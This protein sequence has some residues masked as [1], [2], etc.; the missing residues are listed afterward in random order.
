MICEPGLIMALHVVAKMY[1]PVGYGRTVQYSSDN[2]A[3]A[4]Q[5]CAVY[6]C[7]KVVFNSLAYI[8]M[9]LLKKLK[10]D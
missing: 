7:L 5:G 2:T 4:G 6:R 10:V 8:L 9:R 1:C 3:E